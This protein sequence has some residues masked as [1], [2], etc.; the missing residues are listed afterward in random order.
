MPRYAD[1][2]RRVAPVTTL[3]L[4]VVLKSLPGTEYLSPPITLNAEY[5]SLLPIVA[6]RHSWGS[7]NWFG[8]DKLFRSALELLNTFDESCTVDRFRGVL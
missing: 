3:S 8:G 2:N 5:S 6:D 7:V 1:A 4:L